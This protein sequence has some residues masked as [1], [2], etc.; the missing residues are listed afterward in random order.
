MW[1]VMMALAVM[2]AGIPS[3]GQDNYNELISSVIR[4]CENPRLLLTA[5]FTNDV[6]AYR[7]SCTNEEGRCAADLALALSLMQR[8]DQGESDGA[9]DACFRL[10]QTLV[11]NVAFSSG[12][13]IGSWIRYAAAVEY[14]TGL[15]CGGQRDAVFTLSTNMVAKIARHPPNMGETN[16]WNA[17][18]NWM[19]SPNETLSTVFRLN[20]AIWL[21]ERNRQEEIVP[22]T[23]SLPVR[24]IHLLRE[25]L[26]DQ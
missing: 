18:S 15:N 11:S 1:K 10:H 22:L 26:D 4:A 5:A 12:L 17:M 3:N 16:Y 21:A 24:A 6:T 2:L 7:A 8:M 13:E 9:R 20:A 19:R 14:L 25:E 23:N